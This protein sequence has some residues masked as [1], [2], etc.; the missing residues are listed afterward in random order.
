[1]KHIPDEKQ[2][3]ELLGDFPPGVSGKLDSRLSNA[4]WTPGAV[5]RRRVINT[6]IAGV[7]TLTLLAAVT[8]QGRAVAQSILRYFVRAESDAAT[9]PMSDAVLVPAKSQAVATEPTLTV[10]G[11]CG[12]ILSPSCTLEE[13]QMVA[14]FPVMDLSVN[15]ARL[16]FIGATRTE[17]G[18]AVLV[19]QGDAGTLDLAQIPSEQDDLDAWRIGPTAVVESVAIGNALGEYV[20]GGWFGLGLKDEGTVSWDPESSPQTLRWEEN[21][22]QY[23]LWFVSAKTIDGNPNLDKSALVELAAG[24]KTPSE[25]EGIASTPDLSMQQ[26]AALAGFSVVELSDMPAGFTFSKAAYSSQFN[27]VC[28]YY[29]YHMD[30]I[31]PSVVV[32]ESKWALPSIDEFRTKAFYNGVEVEIATEVET[33]S[34]NGADGGMATLI[35]TG[36]EPSKVCGGEEIHANRALLWQSN[37]KSFVLFAFLDQLDGRGYLTKLEM[38]QLAEGLNG[39]PASPDAEADPERLATAESAEAVTGLDIKSPALMLA[40][41]HLNHVAVLNSGPYRAEDGEIKVA[42]LY[43]GEPVGDGRTYKTLVI[44]TFNST[45]TL[46]NLALGGGYE[47][48]IVNGQPGL[49]QQMCWDEIT[50][51]STPGCMQYL[52]WFEDGVQYDIE[53]FLPVSLP[54]DKLIEI[55]ESLR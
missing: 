52:T 29:R 47:N 31:S 8:P 33:V 13:V 11:D 55:A 45:Q 50:S 22:I 49:H 37:G 54:R 4:P 9:V 17:Q 42:Q 16:H 5:H 18:S 23:T 12:T 30:D 35:T 6:A 27:A 32:F 48:V 51:G 43:T 14:G 19:Y 39:I 46:E 26:A 40:D 1:M 21:G 44:Q 38:R 24:L 53:V 20:R 34:L 3:E 25:S 41:L 15:S 28:L 10:E 2:I 36:I 7:L